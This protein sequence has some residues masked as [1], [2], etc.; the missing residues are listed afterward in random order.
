[1]K[2]FQCGNCRHILL[3]ENTHCESCKHQCGFDP[4]ELNLLTLLAVDNQYAE[5]NNTESTAWRYCKNHEKGVCN[6]LVKADTEVEFCVA[7]ELNRYIPNINNLDN[8]KEWKSLEIAK[9]RLVYS[10]LRMRLPVESKQQ[11]PDSGIVFDFIDTKQ[12]V[13]QDAHDM[14][15]HA[16]GK[17]TV[18]L[19]E[20]NPVQREQARLDMK[21]HYRTLLGHLRHE[22]G[23]YY[24]DILI[25]PNIDLQNRYRALFGDEREDYSQALQRHYEQGPPENWNTHFVTKYASSHPW[26]DWAETWSHYLHLTDVMDTAHSLGVSI[27]PAVGG[28]IGNLSMI[29]DIDPYAELDFNDFLEKALALTF[30]ANSLNRSMGQPDLYPFVLSSEVKNKL[31]FVHC[32]IKEYQHS[33]PV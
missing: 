28:P 14:T 22:I 5:I 2:L 31:A 10:L 13:P 12:V 19:E 6:W 33:L 20:A 21:E 29:A 23:H 25:S 3:F 1:M 24:W 7:C 16:D 15:G 26:E 27:Q 9:H 18:T 17:I 11:A 8:L 4:A 30:A 32:I